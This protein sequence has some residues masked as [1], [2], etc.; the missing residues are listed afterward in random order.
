MEAIAFF[1]WRLKGVACCP[2]RKPTIC[3]TQQPGPPGPPHWFGS[4]YSSKSDRLLG[5]LRGEAATEDGRHRHL[6]GAFGVDS[7]RTLEGVLPVRV[8]NGLAKESWGDGS[9]PLLSAHWMVQVCPGIFGGLLWFDVRTERWDC[10]LWRRDRSTRRP[11][12]CWPPLVGTK[13]FGCPG[14]GVIYL[15]FFY[16]IDM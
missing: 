14:R 8:F 7:R 9:P 13:C 16:P 15:F 1:G 10:L 4:T 5:P 3:F 12:T 2:D 6:S 11:V